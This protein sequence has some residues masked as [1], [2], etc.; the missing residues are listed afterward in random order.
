MKTCFILL[1]LLIAP[2]ALA[3]TLVLDVRTPSEYQQE[4]VAGAVNVEY[5]MI[6]EKISSIAPDKKTAIVLYCRSGRRA[7][8]ALTQLQEM[9]YSHV[10]NAG[11]LES[12]KARLLK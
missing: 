9:G 2:G 8:V 11:G 5:Q 12:M 4:H 3:R 6:S 7:G 10:E 1:M